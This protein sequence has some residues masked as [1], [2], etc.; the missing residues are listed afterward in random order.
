MTKCVWIFFTSCLALSSSFF[1]YLAVWHHCTSV[2]CLFCWNHCLVPRQDFVYELGNQV[3]LRSEITDS[4]FAMLQLL[5]LDWGDWSLQAM[6][7]RSK[8]IHS[9]FWCHNLSLVWSANLV[10]CWVHTKSDRC[11]TYSARIHCPRWSTLTPHVEWLRQPQYHFLVK[12]INWGN[13][14]VT[15]QP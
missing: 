2:L 6:L 7:P 10:V 4:V 5:P 1:C 12:A 13:H 11:V 9:I 3:S 14:P 8:L 15:L